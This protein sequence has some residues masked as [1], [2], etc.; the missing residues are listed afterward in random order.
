MDGSI[1]HAWILT[2][3]LILTYDSKRRVL[4]RLESYELTPPPSTSRI[5]VYERVPPYLYRSRQQDKP[6]C[7]SRFTIKRS[8]LYTSS[9]ECGYMRIVRHSSHTERVGNHS[10]NRPLTRE[11]PTRNAAMHFGGGGDRERVYCRFYAVL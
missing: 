4:P 10:V 8:L 5:G 11:G 2:K 3:L 7:G 9:L 1:K 6:Q